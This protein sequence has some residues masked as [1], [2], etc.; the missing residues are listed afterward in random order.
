VRFS[1]LW[2]TLAVTKRTADGEN[3][4]FPDRRLTTTVVG[5]ELRSV[6]VRWP[7]ERRTTMQPSSVDST[8]VFQS[9]V[10]VARSVTA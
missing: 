4:T 10:T 9:F 7:I 1:P 8:D 2:V 3:D 6:T 5:R